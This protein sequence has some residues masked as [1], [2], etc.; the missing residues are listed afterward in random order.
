MWRIS[1]VRLRDSLIYQLV[2]SHPDKTDLLIVQ[3]GFCAKK[4]IRSH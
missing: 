1:L 3:I 4:N 2:Q